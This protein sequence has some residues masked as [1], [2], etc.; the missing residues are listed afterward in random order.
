MHAFVEGLEEV[1]GIAVDFLIAG[2]GNTDKEVSASLQKNE[3][4]FFE[5]CRKWNVK[6]NESKL[7]QGVKRFLETVNYF[8]KFLPLL[9]DM[10]QPLGKLEDKDIEWCLLEQHEQAFKTVKNYLAKAPVLVT[11]ASLMKLQYMSTMLCK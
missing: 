6:L 9:S 10:F 5:K 11:T 2:F 1:E 4:A 7:K 3:R 8:A